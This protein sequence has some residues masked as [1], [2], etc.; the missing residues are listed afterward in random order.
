MVF[1]GAGDNCAKLHITRLG[2]DLS[3][4][5]ECTRNSGVNIGVIY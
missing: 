4:E 5:L 3:L 1:F 2:V